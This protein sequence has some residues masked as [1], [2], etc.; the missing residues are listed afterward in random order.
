M[1]YDNGTFDEPYWGD[2]DGVIIGYMDKVDFDYEL[3]GNLFGNKIY[4]SPEA[5]PPHAGCGIVEVEVR[6]K[7]V[8]KEEEPIERGKNTVSA[9]VAKQQEK[10]RHADPD[11]EE[12]KRLRLK[13]DYQWRHFQKILEDRRKKNETSKLA[14]S[15][16]ES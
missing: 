4:P 9:K 5:V 8:V 14:E 10:E 16:E 2:E 13:Y 12:W 11:W 3:G 6:L 7:K 15:E 1:R